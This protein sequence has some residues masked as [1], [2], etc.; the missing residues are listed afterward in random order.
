M[1]SSRLSQ[2]VQPEAVSF[3][4]RAVRAVTNRLVVASSVA[5]TDG[6]PPPDGAE[7]RAVIMEDVQDAIR[8]S[9]PAPWMAPQCQRHNLGSI[10][11]FVA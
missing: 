6:V 8:H 2:G 1:C 3:M 7:A 10:S 9:A 5:R 4:Q 11:K